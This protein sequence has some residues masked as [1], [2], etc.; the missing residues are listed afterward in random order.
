[1]IGDYIYTLA[2]FWQISSPQ[3]SV[4]FR[5][6]FQSPVRFF[7]QTK[8]CHGPT[9]M[10]TL[11][12]SQHL[13]PC[14]DYRPIPCRTANYRAP[15]L[16]TASSWMNDSQCNLGGIIK[17]IITWSNLGDTVDTSTKLHSGSRTYADFRHLYPLTA[18]GLSTGDHLFSLLYSHQ[19]HLVLVFTPIG[20]ASMG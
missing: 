14:V 13:G 10:G 15:H 3:D 6:L 7:Q 20:V 9:A 12:Q 18:Q 4:L 5:K 1:M 11:I 17:H 2:N 8:A 19:P 16:Q